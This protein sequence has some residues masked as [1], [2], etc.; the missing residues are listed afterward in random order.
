MGKTTLKI[1]RIGNSRGVRLPAASIRKYR[2]G[3]A[4]VMEERSD[5]ILLRPLGPAVRKLSWEDT[6]REMAT[7]VAAEDWV[8]W[9]ATSM[10]G[11][12]LAPWSGVRGRAPRKKA[13]RS[14]KKSR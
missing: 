7:P 13:A 1:A 4:V 5:G 6:A 12:D 14:G 10:D 3:E 8:D 2:I 11:L 9:D